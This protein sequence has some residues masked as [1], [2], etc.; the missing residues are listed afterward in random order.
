MT[1]LAEL[2]SAAKPDDDF[3]DPLVYR[4]F[5]IRCAPAY[6]PNARRFAVSP[7]SADLLTEL[8]GLGPEVRL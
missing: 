6:P 1:Y 3:G 7:A 4:P 5:A 2:H 8:T